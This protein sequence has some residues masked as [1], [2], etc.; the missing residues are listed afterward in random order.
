MRA[1]KLVKPLRLRLS[2]PPAATL[3]C[4]FIRCVLGLGIVVA[5]GARESDLPPLSLAAVQLIASVL[6]L[7]SA[8]VFVRQQIAWPD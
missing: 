4:A 7:S 3:F 2:V 1:A 5:K 6:A 8:A